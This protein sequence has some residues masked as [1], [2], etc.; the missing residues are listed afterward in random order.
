ML[1]QKK[2]LILQELEN[3]T[4][5]A[6][7]AVADFSNLLSGLKIWF[8]DLDEKH[9]PVAVLKQHGLKGHRVSLT[10]GSFAGEVIAQIRKAPNED[11]L[12][13]RALVASIP[14]TIEVEIPG[15]NLSD[16]SVKNGS[17]QIVATV[18]DLEQPS[19]D[20]AV[21]TTCREILVPLMAAMAELI[22]YDVI[23]QSDVAEQANFEGALSHLV[24]QRRERNPRNRLLCIRTHG[25]FCA[26]CGLDP[27][28]LYGAAGGIIEVHH[29]EPLALL[30][31][32]KAYDPCTDLIPL[33]P[34]CH[35]AIHTRRPVP[36]S[37]EELKAM[38]GKHGD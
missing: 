33:C 37:I 14:T 32:P 36:F 28:E 11:L 2:D 6:I 13:A 4:G 9:G 17:F 16:W 25:E 24:V 19:D 21:I 1:A 10:F 30:A 7:G 26:A 34:S 8:G 31:E 20:S 22:G 38:I 5:A 3:G 18:R 27:K 12:L 15:Q 23:D 35:R 29:L